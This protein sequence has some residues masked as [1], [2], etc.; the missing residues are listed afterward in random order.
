MLIRPFP[1]QPFTPSPILVPSHLPTTRHSKTYHHTPS[2]PPDYIPTFPLD[3]LITTP[4][5][6]PA[7]LHHPHPTLSDLLVDDPSMFLSIPLSAAKS[8]QNPKRNSL[9]PEDE[10]EESH[11]QRPPI[12]PNAVA[13]SSRLDLEPNPFEQSFSRSSHHSSSSLSDRGNTPPRGGEATSTRQNALPPLSSLT[14]P[15]AD[16]SRFPWLANQSLRTGPLSPAML[17]GPQQSSGTANVNAP[18][19]DGANGQTNGE[20]FD[21]STFR[22]GFTPGTGSGFTPGYN[23]LMAGNFASTLPLPSPNT[24][25]F[26]NMVT[27]ATPLGEGDPTQPEGQPQH[28]GGDA[29]DHPPSAI[30]PH[31]QAQQHPHAVPPPGQPMP[32]QHGLSHLQANPNLA[33]ET[34]TPNTLSALTGVFN[35]MNRNQPPPP[36][37]YF[38]PMG[39]PGPPHPM[40]AHP[41]HPGQ[42]HPHHPGMPHVDYAQQSANAAS[43]AANGL[44]LLSQ[45]H[46][47]LSKREEE[48]RVPGKR[49][50]TAG[51]K[52]AA[53]APQGQKRKSD[54]GGAANG[55]NGKP[56]AKKGKKN[57]SP[58]K[59]ESASPMFSDDGDDGS[60]NSGKPETEEEKRKNFLERNRQ[61]QSALLF[62]K[63]S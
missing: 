11:Q 12:R 26:L 30:P 19:R 51:P 50:S 3:P 35:D 53:G 22:T 9:K 55:A 56:A 49:G 25:A 42:P 59:D 15:A 60:K 57:D 29:H 10:Q 44:F 58:I 8:P 27:N 21:G 28:P 17:A 43:Q 7:H 32:P 31:M 5:A 54:A 63:R 39:P 34:I 16:P 2:Q 4:A 62:C 36:P 52:G 61:G 47:E 46:Q 33:Q 41:G 1:P 20:A 45:A 37:N 13:K 23:S 24:A 40:H 14:S 6:P 18:L 38:Q 48:T